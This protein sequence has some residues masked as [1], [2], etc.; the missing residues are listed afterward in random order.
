MAVPRGEVACGE[1]IRGDGF[2][3][4]IPPGRAGGGGLGGAVLG[5]IN[6]PQKSRLV[7]FRALQAATNLEVGS[8]RVAILICKASWGRYNV[9]G[10]DQAVPYLP[11]GWGK[12]S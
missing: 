5:R 11:Q 6:F 2:K 10:R 8:T 4:M 9:C 12:S 3:L 1:Q 7:T